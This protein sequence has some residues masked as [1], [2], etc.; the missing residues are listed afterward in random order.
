[1]ALY[2]KDAEVDELASNLARLTGKSKTA[3]VRAALEAAIA[4]HCN[5]PSLAERV[6]ELQK[7]VRD[8]GFKDDP[9]GRS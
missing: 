2:I 5:V 8:N 9:K 4:T 1:M 3:A 6:L 7:R